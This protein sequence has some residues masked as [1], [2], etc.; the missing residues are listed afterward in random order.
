MLFRLETAIRNFRCWLCKPLGHQWKYF[1]SSAFNCRRCGKLKFV[2]E[3]WR[4][5]G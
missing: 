5:N 3:S 2:E 4:T 1:S